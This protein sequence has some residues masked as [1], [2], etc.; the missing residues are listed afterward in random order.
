[1]KLK[2]FTFGLVV[3]AG[4]A[5]GVGLAQTPAPKAAPKAAP[6]KAAA[7]TAPSQVD[8]VIESVKAGLS[9]S[10][11]IRTL[12]RDNKPADLTT[13]DL[14]KLKNAGVSEN[15]INVMLDPSSTPAAAAAP[16]PAPAPTAAAAPAP[17][18]AP[19]PEPVAAAA[20]AP[21]PSAATTQAQK[22]RVIV[23]EF[24]YSTVK[25]AVQSVFN[26]QQDIGKGIRAMLVT[27]LAQ[28]NKVV[29]VERAKMA[30]LTKE[31]DFNA[32]NRVKQGTGARVG[33]IS[34]ADALLSG[35]IVVFGRDDK[36]KSVK[37]GGLIGGVIGG[38]A[39][40]KNEDK[41]V[42][43]I[44]YR[45]IDAE[46]SEIIA[47][48]EA[49][50]ESVRKGN[51]LGAIGGV[52]GK[53]VAGVQVDMTSSNFA[54]TI[55]GEATQDCVNKLA[56]ILL[57]QTTNMKK[58]VREV[59]GRVADVSGKTLVLNV[60]SNDGVNVGEVFEVLNIIREVKDPVTK[61][62]LDVVTE[63]TGEMTITSVR[64]K[65]ATG[66]YTGSPAKVGFMAR[67]KI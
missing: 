61:E 31:Q 42:V 57:E 17:A 27:R 19:A 23:D 43:T 35:D 4:F 63:K 45:L 16:A 64:D 39:S 44:D 51:A 12:K 41:A 14:V 32:S 54:Q 10:I 58:S 60:G 33:Q 67:K 24:D 49:K 26:T 56:D 36:K 6:A 8:S 25:T 34:G 65:V 30:T 13:A 47:T 55:I 38:I 40:S 5:I 66:T 59:E 2:S 48:G 7:K 22:K 18:P 29:I 3:L 50:G 20:P 9:E 53:G 62:T 11:I 28:A 52:L 1:M 37:G 46:T 21:A 15:I